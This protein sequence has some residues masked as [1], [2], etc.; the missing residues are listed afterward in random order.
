ML[1]LLSNTKAMSSIRIRLAQESDNDQILALSKRCLQEGMI[2]FFV[3]RSPRFNTLQRLLDPDSWHY[4]V[5]DD[6]GIVGQVGVIHFYA[7]MLGET[8][9]FAYMMD[10]RL[11]EGYRKGFTAFRMVKKAID[12]VL[13]SD[14]DFVIGNFLKFNQNSLI[15]A[16]G[17]AGIPEALHLGDNRMFNFLPL[18]NLKTD[19][20]YTIEHPRYDDIPELVR[21]YQSYAE[22]FRIAPHIDASTLAQYVY[23]LD[24]LSL[25]NFLIARDSGRIK[26]VTA[27]WDEHIYKSY[28]VLELTP[29]IRTVNGALRLFSP[30]MN[31]PSPIR[32]NEPLR[33]LSLVLY[34]HDNCPEA[35]KSLFRHVN[36]SHRGSGHTLITLYAQKQDSVFDLLKSCA[37][38]SVQTEMY[39][40]AQDPA[41]YKEL[42]K[43]G[44]PDWLNLELSV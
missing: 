38:V 16:S 9:K 12:H 5:E 33:Q 19:L 43:D 14:T 20:R 40:Y 36:N 3:N 44:R 15:F 4:V 18:F 23:S 25:N 29:A 24:N 27:L 7:R 41:I 26:A 1:K 39:L 22:R 21:I 35:L 8:R 34:A 11:D 31:L 32:L 10:F 6:T 13:S 37:G 42:Q 28:Q 2:T 17:R 30:V